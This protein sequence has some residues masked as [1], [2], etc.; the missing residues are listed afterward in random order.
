MY[1]SFRLELSPVIVLP[2]LSQLSMFGF[3]PLPNVN[4][5]DPKLSLWKV[6]ESLGAHPRLTFTAP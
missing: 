3:G 2:A 6:I 5:V 1:S 4:D